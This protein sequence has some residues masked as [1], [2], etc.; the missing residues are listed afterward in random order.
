MEMT[1][2]TDQWYDKKI[3]EETLDIKALA[4]VSDDAVAHARATMVAGAMIAQA[5]DN[6]FGNE[7]ERGNIGSYMQDVVLHLGQIAER[8]ATPNDE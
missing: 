8:Y 3:A 4:D 2:F 1:L 7:G 6:A 5:I